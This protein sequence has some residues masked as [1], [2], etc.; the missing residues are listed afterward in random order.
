MLNFGDIVVVDHGLVG[1]VVKCWE[2]DLY[3]IYVRS[4]NDI[5]QYKKSE[6]ERFIYDKEL[7]IEEN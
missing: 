1:V 2:N 6:I 7:S 3:E 5:M 4:Y